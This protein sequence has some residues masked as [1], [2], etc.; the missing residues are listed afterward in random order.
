MNDVL[1]NILQ[2]LEKLVMHGGATTNGMVPALVSQAA[3]DLQKAKDAFAAQQGDA[4]ST[5]AADP[6]PVVEPVP[7]DNVSDAP[8]PPGAEELPPPPPPPADPAPEAAAADPADTSA[9]ALNA[10]EAAA[11]PDGTTPPAPAA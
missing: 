1:H 10:D 3:D 7:A 8:A 11:N 2:A 5:P 9:D 4:P 6:P